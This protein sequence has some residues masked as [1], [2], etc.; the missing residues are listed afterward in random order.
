MVGCLSTSPG[1]IRNAAG[2][3][4]RTQ[5]TPCPHSAPTSADKT[6]HPQ[7]PHSPPA[8]WTSWEALFSPLPS[9]ALEPDFTYREGA[10]ANRGQYRPTWCPLQAVACPPQAHSR[11]S[12][13]PTLWGFQ[14]GKLEWSPAEPRIR[15]LL[16]NLGCPTL[17][18]PLTGRNACEL[19]L[20][21][22]NN[23]QKCSQD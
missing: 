9:Y 16:G 12:P 23:N 15:M 11:E 8:T 21:K 2:S 20:Q 6:K 7:F 17:L 4:A 18:M 19:S 1:P 14:G 3:C 13:G 10:M 5:L 22:E